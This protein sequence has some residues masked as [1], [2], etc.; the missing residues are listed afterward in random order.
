MVLNYYLDAFRFHY[1]DFEGRARR[2]E[3]WYFVLFDILT[4]FILLFLFILSE[5]QYSFILIVIYFLAS[6]VPR[7]AINVR[8]LHDIGKSGWYIFISVVPVIGGIWRLVL[9]VTDSQDGE[10]EYGPNPKGIGNQSAEDDLIQNI[11]Q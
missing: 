5:V 1:S 9:L 7:I 11:G 8:R 2:S 3:Y 6:L 10:N 4:I